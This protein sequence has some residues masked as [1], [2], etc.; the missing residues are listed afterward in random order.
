MFHVEQNN[1]P[2]AH[3]IN[4]QEMFHVEQKKRPAPKAKKR[5][6]LPF[7]KKLAAQPQNT[8]K[9][10]RP[11]SAAFLSSCGTVET[12]RKIKR[13]KNGRE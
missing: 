3:G 2:A 5:W 1:Q 4:K 7:H 13:F 9:K 8:Q 12:T 11:K 6:K 10:C